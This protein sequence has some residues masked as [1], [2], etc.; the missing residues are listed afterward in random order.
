MLSKIAICIWGINLLIKTC[1][2]LL[3][4][5][6]QI[7]NYLYICGSQVHC[8]SSVILVYVCGIKVGLGQ[9]E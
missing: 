8:E 6:K 4:I 3:A 5:S 1:G 9:G 2:E 7:L